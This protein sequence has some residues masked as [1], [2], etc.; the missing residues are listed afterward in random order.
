MRWTGLIRRSSIARRLLLSLALCWVVVVYVCVCEC[1]YQSTWK[2]VNTTLRLK[3]EWW[4]ENWEVEPRSLACWATSALTTELWWPTTHSPIFSLHE[5]CVGIFLIYLPHRI[6]YYQSTCVRVCMCVVG[7]GTGVCAFVSMSGW[8]VCNMYYHIINYT[9]CVCGTCTCVQMHIL[10]TQCTLKT[11]T[12]VDY[13]NTLNHH[14]ASYG[15]A[16]ILSLLE[17]RDQKRIYI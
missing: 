13:N 1:V 14:H 2:D 6:T 8:W 11:S 15:R 9:G 16:I 7:G 3:M 12:T 4:K 10:C 17:A 5:R